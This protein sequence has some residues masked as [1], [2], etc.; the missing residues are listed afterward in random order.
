MGRMDGKVAIVT[1]G[2]SGIGAA[3]VRLLAA[4]G[5]KVL[6]TDINADAGQALADELGDNV[7]FA[8]QD[9]SDAAAWDDVIALAQSTFG[10]LDVL[11]NNAGVLLFKGLL[12]TTAEEMDRV[13][14]IN[15]KSVMLGT[16][17]AGKV[18][19]AQGHGS[20]VNVSSVD[21]LTA[22]NAVSAYVASKWG[23]RGFTKAAA[24]ELG[25][26][27]VRVNS[28]HPGGVNTPLAN[29]LGQEAEDFDKGFKGFAAQRA[30]DPIE[31]ATGILFFAS[32]EGRYCMGSELAIDGG[33]VAGHYYHQLPGAPGQ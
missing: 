19:A 5:G 21:G 27:G 33:M 8:R 6:V 3:T 14:N 30:C 26:K 18:L 10:Q 1:G 28:I 23:V 17:A 7:H 15:L 9:V 2:A 31:I 29:I 22:A 32:D 4:E 13:L 24:L 12:D 20:I 11:V 16:I 25:H